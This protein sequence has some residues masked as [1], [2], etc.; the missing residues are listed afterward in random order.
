MGNMDTG[1]CP[2]ERGLPNRGQRFKDAF[3]RIMVLIES[4]D[5][6]TGNRVGQFNQQGS[7]I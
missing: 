4:G 1:D 3:R 7:V 5:I 6:G 2:G